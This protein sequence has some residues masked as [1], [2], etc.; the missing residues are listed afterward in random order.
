MM[1]FTDV[2]QHLQ[3]V[4]LALQGRNKVI[5]EHLQSDFSFQNKITLFQRDLAREI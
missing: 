4:N 2:M 5:T 1:F 3:Y